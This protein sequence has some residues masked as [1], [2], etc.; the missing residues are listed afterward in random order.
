LADKNLIAKSSTIRTYIKVDVEV[1]VINKC[2]DL[3]LIFINN[4][5]DNIKFIN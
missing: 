5:L 1:G 4:T 3:W 2:K